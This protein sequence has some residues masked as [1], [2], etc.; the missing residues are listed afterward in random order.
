MLHTK[1]ANGT[2][3]TAAGRKVGIFV[4]PGF[5]Y[6][7]LAPLMAAFMAASMIVQIVG[8]KSGP[9]KASNGQEVNAQFTFEVSF[10][11]VLGDIW[12]TRP[13]LSISVL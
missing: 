7:Q 6:S 1:S 13:D 2:A 9:V 4:Q 10:A 12:L 8:P 11:L 3:F 5:E